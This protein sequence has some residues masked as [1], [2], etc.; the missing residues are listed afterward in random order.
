MDTNAKPVNLT[1]VPIV[2]AAAVAEQPEV[3]VPPVAVSVDTGRTPDRNRAS[4][5]AEDTARYRL[6][7]EEGPKRGTF[8]YKTLDSMTG[9]VVR[10][11]PREQILQMAQSGNYSAGELIDTSA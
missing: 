9:E 6:I 1:V 3:A 5:R 11:F 4:Q 7:I 2:A 10:Q 8:V